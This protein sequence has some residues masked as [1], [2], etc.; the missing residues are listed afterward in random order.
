LAESSGFRRIPVYSLLAVGTGALAAIAV[1]EHLGILGT[2]SRTFDS[3][4]Y[5]PP[6]KP[7]KIR[8]AFVK[9]RVKLRS[10]FEQ[11]SELSP[12]FCRNFDD[13]LN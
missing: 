3:K 13:P 11:V 10:T 5:R 7:S 4:T 6:S 12:N 9:N 2:T 1:F 8:E